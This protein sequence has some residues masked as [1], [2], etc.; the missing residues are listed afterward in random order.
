MSLNDS[1]QEMLQLVAQHVKQ[2]SKLYKN[3]GNAK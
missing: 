1:E 3:G 2:F